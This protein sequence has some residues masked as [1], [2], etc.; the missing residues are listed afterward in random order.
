MDADVGYNKW[1]PKWDGC[2]HGGTDGRT[3]R[4]EN[5]SSGY[6]DPDN[7]TRVDVCMDVIGHDE[8]MDGWVEGLRAEPPTTTTTNLS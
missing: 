7:G 6:T 3:D 4:Y 2:M 8:R 1:I 5:M